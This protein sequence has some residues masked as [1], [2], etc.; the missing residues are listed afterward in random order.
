VNKGGKISR[1]G[2]PQNEHQEVHAMKPRFAYALLAV[3]IA[4][5]GCTTRSTPPMAG[6]AAGSC[7][8]PLSTASRANAGAGCSATATQGQARITGCDVGPQIAYTG[9]PMGTVG[10][11]RAQPIKPGGEANS[12]P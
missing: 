10:N 8:D 6:T 5:A 9:I 11:P 1:I 3:G 7:D 4:L 2:A 12:C